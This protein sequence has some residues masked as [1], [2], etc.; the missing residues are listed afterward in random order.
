MKPEMAIAMYRQLFEVDSRKSSILL[1]R[2]CSW[3]LFFYSLLL[4]F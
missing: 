2:F 1:L 4:T 3:V